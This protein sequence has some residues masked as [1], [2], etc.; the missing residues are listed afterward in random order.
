MDNGAENQQGVTFMSETITREL[1]EGKSKKL[2]IN[3][4]LEIGWARE[5]AIQYVNDLELKLNK[6]PEGRKRKVSYYRRYTVYGILLIV[7]AII[8]SFLLEGGLIWFALV[9]GAVFFIVGLIGWI[10]YL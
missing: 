2:I 6:S 5:S 8:A 3:E 10:G 4:L 7:G 9:A 1:L